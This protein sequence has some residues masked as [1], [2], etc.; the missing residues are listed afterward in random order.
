MQKKFT[1]MK[2]FGLILNNLWLLRQYRYN[3]VD[4]TL[5]VT[6]TY[7]HTP[8]LQLQGEA[9]LSLVHEISNS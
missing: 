5:E 8:S 6:C 3:S 7:S 2:S 9:T 4:E 1:E